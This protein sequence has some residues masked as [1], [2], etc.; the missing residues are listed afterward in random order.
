MQGF[1]GATWKQAVAPHD[2]LL[3]NLKNDPGELENLCDTHPEKLA[4]MVR[5][6]DAYRVSKGDFPPSLPLGDEEDH[7]FYEILLE[8]HGEDYFMAD[9]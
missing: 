4:E 3:V 7:V 8:R 6:M 9:W 5:L 2:T 1:R